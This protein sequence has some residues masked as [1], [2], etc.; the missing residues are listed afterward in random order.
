[1]KMRKPTHPGERF[2]EFVL[3]QGLIISVAALAMGY[4]VQELREVVDGAPLSIEMAEKWGIFTDTTTESWYNMQV[5]FDEW[6]IEN[7]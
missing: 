2:A 3:N 7:V 6:E 4:R 1:M 5:A